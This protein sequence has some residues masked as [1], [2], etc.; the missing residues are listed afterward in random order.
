MDLYIRH[1]RRYSQATAE[2]VLEAAAHY[3][4]NRF[5][6][7]TPIRAPADAKVFVA[8]QLRHLEDEHFGAL[9]LDTRHRVICWELLFSGTVDGAT[10]YPRVVVKRALK[11]NAAGLILAHN[12]PSGDPEPS[13]ADRSITERLRRAL[14]LIEVR[15]LD[16]LI[17]G[18]DVSSMAER[19]W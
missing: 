10:V 9:F 19:G 1:G 12:H 3:Q 17:V 18:N 8:S 11:H 5:S 6:Q 13:A 4:L 7:G 14:E 2:Q 16:H 15:V